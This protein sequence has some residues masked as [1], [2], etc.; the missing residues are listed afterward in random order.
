MRINDYDKVFITGCGTGVGKTIISAILVQALEADYWKP[1]QSGALEDSDALTVSRLVSSSQ[2][3]VHP[4]TYL[5]KE[6]IS[7]HAAAAREGI[8]ISLDDIHIPS[9]N[10]FLV[11]EG[12]G[13]LLVPI[14]RQHTI[15]DMIRKFK[16]PAIVVSRHY[17][18]SINHTLLTLAALH[19]S[20]IPLL[21]VIFVGD[22]NKE[23]ET[24]ILSMGRAKMLGRVAWE[25]SISPA[26][27][28]QYARL[29]REVL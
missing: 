16:A 29:F 25:E 23:S 21:G 12:A 14:N 19:A 24:A 20:N 11:I 6:P 3:V 15:A 5:L 13:G 26:I 8:E 17:L 18:G 22:P 28:A 27:I 4:E 10:N 1:I 7:P 9:T 2:S